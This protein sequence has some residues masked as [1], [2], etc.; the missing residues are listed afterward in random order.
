MAES[1]LEEGI[2]ERELLQ[3]EEVPEPTHDEQQQGRTRFQ[4]LARRIRSSA[5][6]PIVFIF[7]V[8]VLLGLEG[9]KTNQDSDDST[10]G[11]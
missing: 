2:S 1:H 5:A 7:A 9:E 11:W 3:V 10:V 8:L 4:A 6:F